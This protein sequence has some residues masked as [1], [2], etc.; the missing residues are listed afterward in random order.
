MEPKRKVYK[1]FSCRFSCYNGECN[2]T[3]K[4][5]QTQLTSLIKMIYFFSFIYGKFSPMSVLT[6]Y[7]LNSL[8]QKKLWICCDNYM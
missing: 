4:D 8:W 7:S 6:T 1:E 3:M 5:V 2:D